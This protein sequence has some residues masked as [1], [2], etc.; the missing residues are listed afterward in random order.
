MSDDA[1]DRRSRPFLFPYE[2]L[3]ALRG[4]VIAAV[5]VGWNTLLGIALWLNGGMGPLRDRRALLLVGVACL[6]LAA[7]S[8]SVLA[9][10]RLRNGLTAPS[11]RQRYTPAPYLL[12]AAVAA[13]L[14]VVT[15]G[16]GTGLW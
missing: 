7:L 1:A 4:S 11:R 14:G 10:G 3:L 13:L 9:S 5:V 8:A 2:G 16:S 6:A 12:I 15:L